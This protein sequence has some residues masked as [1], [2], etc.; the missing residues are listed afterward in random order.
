MGMVVIRDI[1]HVVI[2]TPLARTQLAVSNCSECLEQ[3]V[4]NF[5]W[6]Y[7]VV[8]P[9]YNHWHQADLAVGNPTQFVIEIPRRDDRRRT[10]GAATAHF[11]VIRT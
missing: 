10:E 8:L 6:W 7:R 4:L 2:N 11:T 1:S 5:W 9:P 3:R